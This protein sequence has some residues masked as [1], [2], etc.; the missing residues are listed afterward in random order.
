MRL[1]LLILF[2]DDKTRRQ[3]HNLWLHAHLVTHFS[4]SSLHVAANVKCSSVMSISEEWL[5][6]DRLLIKQAAVAVYHNILHVLIF[7]LPW[8]P[9]LWVM[10]TCTHMLDYVCIC[11][12]VTGCISAV[13]LWCHVAKQCA[14]SLTSAWSP[15]PATEE[16]H[17]EY[18]RRGRL[19][20]PC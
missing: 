17:A 14:S 7:S 13:F 1:N 8:H 6:P 4:G 12:C 18:N 5:W 11:V 10:Y 16:P 15:E 19:L 20:E 9:S 3:K 2:L